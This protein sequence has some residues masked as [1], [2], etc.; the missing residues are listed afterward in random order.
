MHGCHL[1]KYAMGRKDLAPTAM[2]IASMPI[3]VDKMHF[4]GH[5]DE[6]CKKN[7]NPYEMEQLENVCSFESYVGV[8]SDSGIHSNIQSFGSSSFPCT[9]GNFTLVFHAW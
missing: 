3:A 1:K 9:Q 2:R 7:S 5:V 4:R 6:W 8:Y